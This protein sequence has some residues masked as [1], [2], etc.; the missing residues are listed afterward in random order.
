MNLR[1][2]KQGDKLDILV[3]SEVFI[4]EMCDEYVVIESN[5]SMTEIRP[6]GTMSLLNTFKNIK[7]NKGEIKKITLARTDYKDS[8]MLTY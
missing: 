6:N 2:F 5:M 3:P 4:I 7:I 1:N 8:V